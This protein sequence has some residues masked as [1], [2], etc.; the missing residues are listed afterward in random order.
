MADGPYALNDDGT[1]KDPAAFQQALKSDREKM[2]ALKEEPETLRI[3]MGDDMHAFQELIKGVYQAE[4]KR[5]ERASKSLSERTIDAQRASAT[6]PRDT[7]QLYQ[8]L[9]ASGLQY[10]PAFRLLRNVH[11]PD[12]SAQ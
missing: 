3:V 9:H 6:V 7:V 1:A 4:K 5:M 10:G 12:L 2:Q 11:T 8:Q